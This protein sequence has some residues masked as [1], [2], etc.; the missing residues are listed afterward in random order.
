[1]KRLTLLCIIFSLSYTF[2]GCAQNDTVEIKIHQLSEKVYMLEGN[3]G[4]IGVSVGKDGVFMIDDQFADLTPKILAAIKTISDKPLKF[5]VNTHWHGDHTGGNKNLSGEGAIIV[6]HENVR[7]RLSTEQFNKDWNKTTPPSPNEALPVVTFSKDIT[8]H[9]N[10]ES[11]FVF[12]VHDAHTD[13]DAMV[14]FEQDNV[15][16]MGDIYFQGKYPFIDLNS[17]GSVQGY[18]DAIAK[19]LLLI[20]DDTKIIP[21]HRNVSSKHELSNYLNMLNAIKAKVLIAIKAGNTEKEVSQNTTITKTYDDLNYGDWFIDSE[22]IR[23][24][25]YRSLKN[26]N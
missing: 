19:A 16:H 4:N 26:V 20:N 3:G 22:T 1:M 9:F 12:H 25:F 21:G 7:K 10:D 6:A 14:Y 2:S 23:K 5:L 24:T 17:G 18:I 8:F 15:L 13:G 11:I